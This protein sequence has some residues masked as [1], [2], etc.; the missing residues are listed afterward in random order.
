MLTKKCGDLKMRK[1]LL[2]VMQER[3]SHFKSLGYDIRLGIASSFLDET[4]LSDWYQR[5]KEAF[6]DE[7]LLHDPLTCSISSHVGPNAFG[8]GLS[9]KVTI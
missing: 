2:N 9:V 8:M 3:A 5:A 4:D 7:E 6:P 1:K